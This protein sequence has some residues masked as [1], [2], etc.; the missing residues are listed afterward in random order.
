MVVELYESGQSAVSIA[1]DL[2]IQ[3]ALVYRW[4]QQ[5]EMH[6]SNSFTGNGNKVLT[7]EQKELAKLK[8]DLLETQLE[9][10]ILKK[11][12]SIFSKSDR[13]GSDL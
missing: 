2:G 5:K 4:K 10:D 8:K 13:K 12:I 7:A 11:A 9:R 1:E 3:V 6:G